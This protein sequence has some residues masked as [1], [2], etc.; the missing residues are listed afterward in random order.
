LVPGRLHARVLSTA[1]P[2]RKEQDVF[3]TVHR[4]N[5][6]GKLRRALRRHGFDACVYGYEAE[7]S[8]L[9]FSPVLYVLG[10][11]HQRVA[12]G[13]FKLTLVAYGRKRA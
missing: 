12:P 9:A 4:C 5:T 13:A 1:Q 8:Y 10:V 11:L 6:L 7:P 3:P 2:E